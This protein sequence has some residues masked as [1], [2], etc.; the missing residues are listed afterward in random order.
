MYHQQGQKR[1][2]ILVVIHSLTCV[3]RTRFQRVPCPAWGDRWWLGG[4]GGAWCR[5]SGPAP[6]SHT[7]R[8]PYS[9]SV[10]WSGHRSVYSASVCQ[11]KQKQHS[12]AEG[13]KPRTTAVKI[14][15]NRF[16]LTS[17]TRIHFNVSKI[18]LSLKNFGQQRSRRV[19]QPE[20]CLQYS[21]TFLLQ[22]FGFRVFWLPV[23][24]LYRLIF[25]LSWS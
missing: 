14:I 17:F 6:G 20:V 13:N 24:S 25:T 7:Y 16:T 9:H 18:L 23:Y 5:H 1:L 19:L 15:F 2:Y 21:D 12:M 8:A 10:R 4:G 11:K 3:W 22:C